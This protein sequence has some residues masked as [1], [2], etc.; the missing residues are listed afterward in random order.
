MFDTQGRRNSSTTLWKILP[1]AAIGFLALVGGMV[2]L[3]QPEPET[4][5]QLTGIQRQGDPDYEWYRKYVKL[6]KPQISMGRNFAG[7]RMVMFSGRIENG[8]EKSLDLVEVKLVF[9]NYEKPVWEMTRIP[10]RP[11]PGSYTLPIEPFE[12]RGFT[13]YVEDV[14]EQWR[15]SYAEMD[16]HGF[17]FKQ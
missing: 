7:K 14:P 1:F 13:L 11:A 17:R 10:I 16:I 8:G 3:L 5:V 9:F 15:A 12:T 2:Y 4:S 6:E